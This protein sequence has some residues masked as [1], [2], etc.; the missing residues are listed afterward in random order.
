MRVKDSRVFVC[1][2]CFY[3]SFPLRL[4]CGDVEGRINALFNRVNAI[5]KKSGQFDV[6]LHVFLLFQSDKHKRELWVYLDHVVFQ[7]LLCVG[8]FF[9]NSPEAEAEWEAYKSGAK[10][11]KVYFRSK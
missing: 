6:S 3:I 1:P 5:Q 2:R 8:E 11:G 10:K 7:L 4:A 9:V